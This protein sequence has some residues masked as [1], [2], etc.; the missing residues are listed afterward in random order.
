MNA[1]TE[2]TNHTT[3]SINIDELVDHFES[4]KI[5]QDS[6]NRL[7]PIIE[8]DITQDNQILQ[9]QYQD[10]KNETVNAERT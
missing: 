5:N 4:I 6:K 7:N 3:A 10:D 8:H 2:N 9:S 1:K